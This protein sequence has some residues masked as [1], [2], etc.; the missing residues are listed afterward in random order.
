MEEKKTPDSDVR[1]FIPRQIAWHRAR[2]V[3]APG[4]NVPS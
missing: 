4:Y 1:C 3:D 2:Q